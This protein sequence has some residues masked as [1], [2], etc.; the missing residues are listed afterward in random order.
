[1]KVKLNSKPIGYVNTNNKLT[2]AS[3]KSISSAKQDAPFT[4]EK[5]LQSLLKVAHNYFSAKKDNGVNSITAVA[6]LIDKM[7]KLY[8]KYIEEL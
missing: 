8:I 6:N 2:T 4:D 1:M 7:N 5:F 3:S